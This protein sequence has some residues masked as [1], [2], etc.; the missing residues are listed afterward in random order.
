MSKAQIEF[1]QRCKALNLHSG[2]LNDWLDRI[3]AQQKRIQHLE[4]ALADTEALEL[5]T[6]EKLAASQAQI[7]V[8]RD[9][10]E[11]VEGALDESGMYQD[12]PVTYDLVLE[13][14]NQP[15]DDSA[16]RE[17]KAGYEAHIKA[18]RD[19]LE[20]C[21]LL[22]ARHRKEEWATHIL[23]FCESGG[24][25][26]NPLRQ[27]DSAL[28]ERLKAEREACAVVCEKEAADPHNVPAAIVARRCAESIREME[29]Q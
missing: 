15:T 16:L 7:K 12:Y 29:D 8:L 26:A 17:I 24:S 1:L 6:A 13:A 10:L 23:R 14:L 3:E 9:A 22:A 19:A 27:D 25:V 4:F 18:L 11:N 20:N 5:G 21:R 28:R 2:S